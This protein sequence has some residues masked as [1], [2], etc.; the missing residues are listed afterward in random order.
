MCFD[1]EVALNVLSI[2]LSRRFGFDKVA[3]KPNKKGF[4]S[5][6]SAYIVARE[7]SI[8]HIFAS[9][10]TGDPYAPLWKAL[11]KAKVPSKVAIFGWR[12]A[13]NLLP[14]RV[15]LTAKGYMGELQ[16]VVC[17]QLV[18][19]LEHVF[20]EC[21]VARD[22]LSAP[23]FFLPLSTL[24]WKEWLLERATTLPSAL[25]DKLLILLWSLWRNRNDALW[26][27]HSQT[28]SS[29]VAYSLAWYEEYLQSQKSFNPTW[30]PLKAS[31]RWLAPD[32]DTL[33]M[34]VDGAFL[35]SFQHGG[36]GGG[37]PPE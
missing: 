12:A 15:A 14:T 2:P 31:K 19:S 11:W 18:E 4:F 21:S 29:L 10:S 37:G 13:L 5:V 7:F 8:G 35:P 6:K 25:F 1:D 33:K 23:P 30:A 22:I 32:V 28:S 26:R 34:N 3:W 24:P 20:C 9:A 36:T 27:N 16:C 17:S